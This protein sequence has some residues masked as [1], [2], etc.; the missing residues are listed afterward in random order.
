[1]KDKKDKN[2]FEKHFWELITALI[3]LGGIGATVFSAFASNIQ[4]F[5]YTFWVVLASE[6]LLLFLGCWNLKIKY[7]FQKE[8]NEMEEILKNEKTNLE[9]Q[10][11]ELQLK[12]SGIQIDISKVATKFKN[13]CKLNNDF[14]Y[15]IPNITIKTYRD[16]EN[17][18]QSTL[19]DDEKKTRIENTKN[20]FSYSL[21]E[22]YKRYTTNILNETIDLLKTY[23]NVR[24]KTQKLSATVKL[25]DVPYNITNTN[26]NDI[27]VYTA[28]RDKA[29]FEENKREIGLELYTIRGNADFVRCLTKEH[30]IINNAK[31]GDGSYLNEH[32][33]FDTYYNCAIVVPIRIKQPNNSMNY[34]GYLCC[35]CLNKDD[36]V[37]VFDVGSSDLLFSI[38]QLYSMF[39]ETLN[40]NWHERY[41]DEENPHFLNL[42]FKYSYKGKR[43]NLL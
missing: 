34:F 40:S 32:E 14:C 28:F 11:T 2:F 30:F 25:F 13:I 18:S 17:L 20:D 38:A 7:S 23:L 12:E 6:L 33:D 4:G 42:I 22:L 21:Y 9:K 35:D 26:A 41:E 10:N 15:K 1:M 24:G 43:G 5:H 39:L 3:S 8:K 36:N 16:I 29:T 31:R 19:G 37:D 27:K